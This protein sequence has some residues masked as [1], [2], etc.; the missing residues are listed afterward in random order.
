[1]T[2]SVWQIRKAA[3]RSSGRWP[4]PHS[5]MQ[6]CP[7]PRRGSWAPGPAASEGGLAIRFSS[8]SVHVCEV[9]VWL[10]FYLHLWHHE[11]WALWVVESRWSRTGNS[12]VQCDAAWER[13]GRKSDLSSTWCFPRYPPEQGSNASTSVFASEVSTHRGN[14]QRPL[15]LAFSCAYWARFARSLSLVFTLL[16]R[17]AFWIT[18]LSVIPTVWKR[19]SKLLILFGLLITPSWTASHPGSLHCVYIFKWY[20]RCVPT[21]WNATFYLFLSLLCIPGR[22]LFIVLGLSR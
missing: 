19:E 17:W 7:P 1:M 20:F 12:E 9:T 4:R 8:V 11:H 6:P 15:R 22:L 2:P 5:E 13:E 16:P 14:E 18:D 3:E 21:A 10:H